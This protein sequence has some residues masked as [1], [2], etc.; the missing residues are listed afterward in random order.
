[1]EFTPINTQEEFE[2]ALKDRL[3]QKERAVA[4]K[5]KGYTSPDDLKKLQEDHDT[6]IQELTKNMEELTKSLEDIKG[7]AAGY[8]KEITDRDAKIKTYETASVKARIA[9]EVGIP[10]ELSNR[11]NGESEEDIRKDA[12][13]IKSFLGSGGAAPLKDTEP[14]GNNEQAAF[15]GML[16][17]LKGE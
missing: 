6:K 2:A 1:M 3:A 5:Y 14:S 4:E 16:S 17:Q 11:L 12:E 9:H 8:E 10:Y 7:K 13:S 15:K